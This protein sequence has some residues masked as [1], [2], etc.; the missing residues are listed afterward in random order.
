MAL[1]DLRGWMPVD[2]VVVNGRPGLA[3]IDMSGVRLAEPFFQQTIDRLKARDPNREQLFTEFDTLVQL[4]KQFDSVPPSGFI[5]HSSRCG[6]TLLANACRALARQ[7]LEIMEIDHV[8]PAVRGY[9]A[10]DEVGRLSPAEM[11]MRLTQASR[12]SH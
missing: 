6:S 11:P 7:V 9:E 2:A 1:T 5:F 12:R 8:E 10:D 4:E 3:W